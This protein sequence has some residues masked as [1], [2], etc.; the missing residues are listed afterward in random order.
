MRSK[1]ITKTNYLLFEEENA[2][3]K[4]VS[5]TLTT[6][7][8]KEPIAGFSILAIGQMLIQET[9]AVFQTKSAISCITFRLEWSGKH[10]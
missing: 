1:L 4:L 6:K 2:F 10:E 5:H 3:R 8:Y 7:K 9:F